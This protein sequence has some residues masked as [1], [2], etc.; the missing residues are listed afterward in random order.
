MRLATWHRSW[1]VG[2]S[3]DWIRGVSYFGSHQGDTA[4]TIFARLWVPGGSNHICNYSHGTL[5][6][7]IGGTC[8][9]PEILR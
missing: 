8:N 5:R 3:T 9:F 4:F 2:R 1:I 7:M 6:L